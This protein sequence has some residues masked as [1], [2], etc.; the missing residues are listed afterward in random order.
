LGS[1]SASKLFG[2]IKLYNKFKFIKSLVY[3]WNMFIIKKGNT[4]L[5][6]IFPKI[7]ITKDSNFQTYLTSELF[8]SSEGNPHFELIC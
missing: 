3:K 2:T 1:S 7:K 6:K 5:L 4:I 8:T